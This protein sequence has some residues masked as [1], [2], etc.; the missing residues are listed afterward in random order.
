MPNKE[1]PTNYF[2]YTLLLLLLCSS[3]TVIAQRTP[4][5]YPVNIVKGKPFAG[6]IVTDL[7]GI[8]YDLTAPRGTVYVLNFWFINCAP[9]RT[10]MPEL[11]TLVKKYKTDSVIFLAVANDGAAALKQF[12]AKDDV[13]FDYRI[14][15]SGRGFAQ[16]QGVKGYPT[17][18]VI[19]KDGT[20]SFVTAGLSDQTI[21]MLEQAIRAELR[22][23]KE[24]EKSE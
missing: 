4:S 11:N 9:C 3:G 15:P 22:R 21:P 7:Q 23:G 6:S 19:A 1:F 14:V 17:H 12:L 8:S 18:A 5:Y 20:V 10:E 13:A 24:N 2:R 16:Q